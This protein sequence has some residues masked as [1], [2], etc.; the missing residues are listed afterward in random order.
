MLPIEVQLHIAEYLDA[1]ALASLAL[2]NKRQLNIILPLLSKYQEIYSVRLMYNS[3]GHRYIYQADHIFACGDNQYTQLGLADKNYHFS[4]TAVPWSTEYGRIEQIVT[5]QNHTLLLTEDK[6]LWVCGDNQ[7]GQLGLGDCYQFSKRNKLGLSSKEWRR[8]TA[9]T[10]IEV[11]W[12]D[13]RGR[14]KQVFASVNHTLVLTDANRLWVCGE[15][16]FGQLGLDEPLNKII[17][18]TEVPW[19]EE[20]G[21]ICQVIPRG[22]RTF[23][24]SQDN[25]LWI[26]DDDEMKK[27]ELS[28]VSNKVPDFIE[29]LL[30]WPNECGRIIQVI[31]SDSKIYMLT[32]TSQLWVCENQFDRWCLDDKKKAINCIEVS[33]PGEHGKIQQIF[34]CYPK[35]YIVLTKDNQLWACGDNDRAQLGLGDDEKHTN[36]TQIP[37]PAERGRIREIFIDIAMGYTVILT[38]NNHLWFCGD[39]DNSR[40]PLPDG[41]TISE[42]KQTKGRSIVTQFVQV[43]RLPSEMRLVFTQ[44]DI[45]HQLIKLGTALAWTS[46]TK[47]NVLDNKPLNDTDEKTTE[48]KQAAVPD[49][50]EQLSTNDQKVIEYYASPLTWFQKS[51]EQKQEKDRETFSNGFNFRY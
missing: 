17:D 34:G 2:S 32:E 3:Y 21:Q 43:T 12:P 35:S 16:C 19:P 31:P 4:F 22:S 44:H 8:C 14:I 11:L 24:L 13:E 30:L 51:A 45:I 20:R 48:E 5:G 37:W 6:R 39:Y 50:L 29:I 28:E 18:F 40:F 10:F 15:N 23:V 38:H 1:F 41:N 27:L 46:D 36:L 42:I 47:L 49:N 9:N 7:Y 25:R 33:W 26:R